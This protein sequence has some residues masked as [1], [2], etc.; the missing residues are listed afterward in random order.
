[1]L[2]GKITTKTLVNESGL[3]EKIKTSTTKEEKKH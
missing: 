1:M 2:D 3:N